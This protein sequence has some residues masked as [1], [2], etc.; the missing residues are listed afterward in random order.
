[1][2]YGKNKAMSKGGKKG[3]KKKAVDPFARKEWYK[4]KA[5]SNFTNRD[6]GHT[7]VNRTQGTK[8]ASEGLK[9]RV[10]E[11]SHGDL[12]KSDETYR[13]FR[14]ICEDVQGKHCLTNFHGMDYTRDKLC[15]MV[16]KWQTLIEMNMSVKTT[17]GYVLRVFCIAFTKK[18]PQAKKKTAYAKHAK[19]RA[20]RAKMSEIIT[21]EFGSAE[22]KEVVNKLI[23]D[24][25][26]KDIDRECQ[27]IYPLH[28]V[29]IRKVKVVRKPK[30]D[31]GKLMEMHGDMKSSALTA[32]DGEVVDKPDGYEPQVQES[33]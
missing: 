19:V 24:S 7:L 14:L 13:K 11:V 22:L 6:I 12:G 15:S 33:V 3:N 4:A 2:A 1:M 29:H 9:G 26:C 17:D 32:A 10:F 31:L 30:F 20:I 25:V 16:R 28:E 23:H 27:S 5:P 8:I 21:K 18:N